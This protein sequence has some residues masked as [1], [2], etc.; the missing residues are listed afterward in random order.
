MSPWSLQFAVEELV[1]AHG[2]I[3]YVDART[4]WMDDIVKQAQWQ[5]IT[6]VGH[7]LP[8]SPV[9]LRAQPPTYCYI[10]HGTTAFAMA[11]THMQGILHFAHAARDLHD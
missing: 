3:N 8:A 5:G 9:T 4:S 10:C 11:H 7:M 1:G 6:Q 2:M